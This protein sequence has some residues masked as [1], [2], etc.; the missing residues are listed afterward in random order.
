MANKHTVSQR[1]YDSANCTFYYLKY[2]NRTDADIIEKLASVKSKADYIR[3]LIRKDIGSV[4]APDQK[5]G[6]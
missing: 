6:E 4:P 3:Q 1:K 5:E 2:N